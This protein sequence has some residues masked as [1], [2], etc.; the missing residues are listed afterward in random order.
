MVAHLGVVAG[1]AQD[2]VNAQSGSAQQL[3]LQSDTVTVTAGQLQNGGQTGILQHNASGQAAH[4]HDGGLVIGN[5][6]SS[7]AGQVFLGFLN[8]MGSVDALGGADF[9]GNDKLTVIKQFG[10]SHYCLLLYFTSS[11][12]A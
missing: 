6:D 2:V 7:N 5:I 10:N 4:T 3:G 11:S 8:N 12:V 9:S 1:E